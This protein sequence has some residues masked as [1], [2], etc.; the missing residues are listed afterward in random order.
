M[1]VHSP[2]STSLGSRR[3]DWFVFKFWLCFSLCGTYV[4]WVLSSD[5]YRTPP[6]WFWFSSKPP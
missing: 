6:G 1:T 4:P 5:S 3:S 2:P